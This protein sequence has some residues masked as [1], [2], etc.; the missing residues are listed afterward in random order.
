M[1]FLRVIPLVSLLIRLVV[2]VVCF[3]FI[4][5]IILAANVV[6]AIIIGVA[7]GLTDIALDKLWIISIADVFILYEAHFIF[8]YCYGTNVFY[9]ISFLFRYYSAIC[10][11]FS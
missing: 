4:P 11:S 7:S 10:L 8:E 6:V 1:K 5:L 2:G 9:K 3:Y